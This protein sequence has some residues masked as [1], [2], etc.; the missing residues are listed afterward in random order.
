MTRVPVPFEPTPT[1]SKDPLV[2]TDPSPLTIIEPIPEPSPRFTFEFEVETLPP[3]SIT[4]DPYAVN[5]TRKRVVFTAAPSTSTSVAFSRTS[6][7]LVGTAFPLQLFAS[8]QLVVPAP[9]SHVIVAAC[10]T[11]TKQDEASN[12]ARNVLNGEEDME[13]TQ[14]DKQ[15]CGQR[16]ES[17]PLRRY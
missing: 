4:S 5:P 8:N 3:F 17:H 12:A 7:T 14:R 15:K 6:S 13:I 10:A 11:G 16:R 9:P 2:K 1:K